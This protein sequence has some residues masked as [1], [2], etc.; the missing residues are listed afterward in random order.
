MRKLHWISMSLVAAPFAFMGACG[1]DDTTTGGGAGSSS[2]AGSGGS[3]TAGTRSSGGSS[4]SGTSSGGSAGSAATAGSSGSG[5]AAT[6]GAAGTSAP[7]SGGSGTAS[8]G[9]AAAETAAGD[10]GASTKCTLANDPGNGKSCMD[11]CDGY[12]TNCKAHAATASKYDNKA[13][14]V[15]DCKTLTQPQ[16]CCRANHAVTLSAMPTQDNIDMHCPH[17][18]GMNPCT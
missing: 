8:T 11:L 10:N 1:G 2:T 15:T 4:G 5:G 7:D 3:G 18:I 6:G 12:F 13:A 14:C 17:L 9:D 16:L